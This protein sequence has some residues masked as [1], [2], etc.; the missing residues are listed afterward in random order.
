V[1]W[2]IWITGVPGSGKSAIARAAV[3]ALAAGGDFVRLLELDALRQTL[4]PTPL[5][6]DSERQAVYRG[7]V[8]I[9][10]ELTDAGVPVII[11]AT[12]H[13]REWRDLARQAIADF[14][15]VQLLCPLDVARERERTRGSGHHPRAIYARAGQPGATVPGVNVPYEPAVA[16]EVTVDTT[17]ETVQSAA[18]RVAALGRA[19]A[20]KRWP[21]PAAVGWT[22]WV[23]GRAGS[24]KTPVVSGI[25]E[26][27]LARGDRVTV[28][29]PRRVVADITPAGNPSHRERDII[30]RV[31][32]TAAKLLNQAG[33]AVLIDG[34]PPLREGFRLGRELIR[35]IA[36]VDLLCSP[37]VAYAR[38]E[39]VRWRLATRYAGS[40]PAIAPLQEEER[41]PGADLVIRTDTLNACTI[42]E[43]M[44]LVDR[45]A[46]C[47]RETPPIYQA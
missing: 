22:L 3:A 26:R 23:T 34:P 47:A 46:R 19:L 21:A 27:L 4:T 38:A 33:V 29:D 9:A 31:I 17:R 20:R 45:L 25:R 14:A 5:Y 10:R 36:C 37:A 40:A 44:H 6:D 7:L 12:G 1:S 15:E 41:L 39:A 2:A 11:D 18:R 8:V 30:T 32:V 43:V 24:G 13:R 16:P 42:T 28:L 35:H